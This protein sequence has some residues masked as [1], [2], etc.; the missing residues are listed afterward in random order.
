MLKSRKW[1]YRKTQNRKIRF[2]LYNVPISYVG[3]FVN[4]IW[5]PGRITVKVGAPL[6]F[7]NRLAFRAL[8]GDRIFL[9]F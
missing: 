7:A 4:G 8:E 6:S 1:S 3:R 2:I 5:I 9:E